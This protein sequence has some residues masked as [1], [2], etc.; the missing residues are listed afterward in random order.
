MRVLMFWRLQQPYLSLKEMVAKNCWPV[1]TASFFL[2]EVVA[3]KISGKEGKCEI[4][5]TH[6]ATT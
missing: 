3:E 5:G 4:K 1:S 6:A 2:Q